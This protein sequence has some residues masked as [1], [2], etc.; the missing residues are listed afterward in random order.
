MRQVASPGSALT[1]AARCHQ[2]LADVVVAVTVAVSDLWLG[3]GA[4]AVISAENNSMVSAS[5]GG[6]AVARTSA[7]TAVSVPR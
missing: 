5:T 2:P 4:L 6:R 1:S 3:A 7:S